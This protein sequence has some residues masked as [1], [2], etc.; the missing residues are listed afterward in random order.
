MRSE[1]RELAAAAVIRRH[2]RAY[3]CFATFETLGLKSLPSFPLIPLIPDVTDRQANG[4]L[5]KVC[6]LLPLGQSD[7]LLMPPTPTP[8]PPATPPPPVQTNISDCN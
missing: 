4:F 3:F 1:A 2:L 8:L 5:W 7:S 6:F